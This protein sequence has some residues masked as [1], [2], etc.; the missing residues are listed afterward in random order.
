M[1]LNRRALEEI[2]D[3]NVEV[4]LQFVRLFNDTAE[5]CLRDMKNIIKGTTHLHW[6]DV[7]HEL[8]GAAG[9]IR[10]EELAECCDQAE[11]AEDNALARME[12]YMRVQQAY[13]QLKSVMQGR[14]LS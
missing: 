9:N 7:V 1:I 11:Q 10:A 5:R 14:Q 12:A 4:E 8:K 3:G 6:Q 2:T 13:D